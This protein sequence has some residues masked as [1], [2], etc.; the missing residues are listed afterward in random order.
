MF[1][2][3]GFNSLVFMFITETT[4]FGTFICLSYPEMNL[5]DGCQDVIW[6]YKNVNTTL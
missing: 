5:L 1:I 4:Q 2:M 6:I 3:E